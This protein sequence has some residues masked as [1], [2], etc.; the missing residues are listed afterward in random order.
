MTHISCRDCR[1]QYFIDTPGINGD[2]QSLAMCG[3]H[4]TSSDYARMQWWKDRSNTIV[5]DENCGPQ[6]RFYQRRAA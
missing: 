6:A 4:K 3:L 2:T 1:H 5:S